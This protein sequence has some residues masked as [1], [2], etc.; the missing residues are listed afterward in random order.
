MLRSDEQIRPADLLAMLNE[1]GATYDS[2]RKRFQPLFQEIDACG[3]AAGT[4]DDFLRKN[5]KIIVFRCS[6]GFSEHGNQLFDLMIALLLAYQLAGIPL[7][8][9]CDEIQ[10]QNMS[11]TSPIGR[12]LREGRKI[13]ASFLGAT[14]DYYPTSTALGSIM[15][16]ASTQ[17]FLRPTYNSEKLVA[18]ALRFR[19]A[20]AARFDSMQRG[21]AIIKSAF[22][23]KSEKRNCEVILTGKIVPFTEDINDED[24]ENLD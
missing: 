1:D 2:L 8:I 4:L 11:S 21:D 5:E 19:K 9:F 17:I 10:N 22:Y 14:Q 20:D 12:V 23:H 3:M 7:D 18:Q 15:G 13:N 16:K 6:S 24:G